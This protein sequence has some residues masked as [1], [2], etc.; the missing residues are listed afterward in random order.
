MGYPGHAGCHEFAYDE[1]GC[2]PTGPHTT[3]YERGFCVTQRASTSLPY[4][5]WPS[6]ITPDFLTSSPPGVREPGTN[7]EAM[8]WVE[9]RPQEK[10]RY[11]LVMQDGDGTREV[12]PQPWSVRNRAHEYGGGSWVAE[13]ELIVFSHYYDHRLYRIDGVGTEPRPITPEGPWRYA[14]LQLDVSSH[15]LYAVRE[16]H[17][18]PSTEPVNTLVRLDI[19]G[20]NA[21]GGTVVAEGSDFISSPRLSADRTEIAWLTW[22]HPNMPWDESALWRATVSGDGSLGEPMVV[23]QE[24]GVSVTI[25]GWDR[26]GRLI[27]VSDRTGWWHL[28]RTDGSVTTQ[29]TDG[30]REFG[31]PQWQ[32]GTSTWCELADGTLAVAWTAGG[33]WHLGTIASDAREVTPLAES[34]TSLYNL[35]TH[36]DGQTVF[37]IAGTATEP[38]RLVQID[39]GTGSIAP[40]TIN[41]APTVSAGYVSVAEPISWPTP[42]GS[43]AHGLYYPPTNQDVEPPAGE[44]PPLIVESHGGPTSFSTAT[45]DLEKQFWTSRGFAVLDVNYGGSTGYGRAYRNRLNGTWG[46]VD[47]DDC[48]SGA[49]HLADQGLVD[50]DRL[51]IRGGSAGGYTTLAALAFRNIFAAGASY[52]GIGDLEAMAADTHKFESRYLDRLVGPYPDDLA[53]YHERSAI[54]HVDRLD[55]PMILFQGLD[56]KVV[57]PNQSASMAEAVRAKELPVALLEFEGEGHGF[58]M[59]ETIHRTLEAE[60]SFYG[61]VFGF[62]PAGDI[63]RLEIDNLPSTSARR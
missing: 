38:S 9:V 22:N 33:L 2:R 15:R 47:V 7:G 51:I 27:Y 44:L 14:D 35:H 36:P 26:Q 60:I 58:R 48:I 62:E 8:F 30:E 41:D 21:N 18:D 24:P 4:G 13:G 61:Q 42:D 34:F 16:D 59:A 52:Y 28:Y 50:R 45:F 25:P 10:G 46:I 29:L 53:T 6:P 56:D 54:H 40:I 5:A 17:S 3:R 32:F 31:V 63:P 19:D 57:P 55:S 12:T 20:D 1:P 11:V 37:V 49:L 43:T 39:P 23:A